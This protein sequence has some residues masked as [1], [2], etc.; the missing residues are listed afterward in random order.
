MNR[1]SSN[2]AASVPSSDQGFGRAL[3]ISIAF[4]LIAV[5]AFTLRAVFY[6]SDMIDL[7]DS[8]RVDMVALP[9]K[10]AALPPEPAPQPE[11][12]PAPQVESKPEP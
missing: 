2:S 12:T 9:D 7:Q 10:Q 6:P 5:A 8:I 11:A 3:V 1:V 4:H